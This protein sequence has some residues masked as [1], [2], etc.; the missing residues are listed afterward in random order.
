VTLNSISPTF[1]NYS[2]DESGGGAYNSSGGE[3]QGRDES[4][5]YVMRPVARAFALALN[6][7]DQLPANALGVDESGNSTVAPSTWWEQAQAVRWQGPATPEL[8]AVDQ[9]P[10][11]AS[12]WG[13]S[14]PQQTLS[15]G[16]PHSSQ[17]STDESGQLVAHQLQL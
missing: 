13:E 17:G 12:S 9:P 7:A 16:N 4:G 6:S 14:D 10:A 3:D 5:S 15:N 1:S 11:Q 2:T 8:P